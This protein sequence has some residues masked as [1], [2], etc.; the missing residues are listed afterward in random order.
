MNQEKAIEIVNKLIFGIQ[1][2]RTA[3]REGVETMAKEKTKPELIDGVLEDL[4]PW[5]YGPKAEA[6]LSGLVKVSDR[7]T[8]TGQELYNFMT[9]IHVL[10]PVIAAMAEILANYTFPKPNM[11]WF[12]DL[13]M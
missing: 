4:M 2:A 6:F 8:V 10:N 3:S 5:L 13:G 1:R 12:R 11:Q 7:G 9:V